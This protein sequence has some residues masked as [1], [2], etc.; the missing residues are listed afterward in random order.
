[1]PEWKEED[2][3]RNNAF[4]YMTCM[5]TPYHK[6]PCPGGNQ[7]YNFGGPFILHHNCTLGLSD[8]CLRV[9]KK[10]LKEIMHFHYMTY[11]ASLLHKNPCLGG[12]EI[13]NFGRPFLCHQYYTLSLYG[14]CQWEEKKVFKKYSN[15]IFIY[16]YIYI[17]I[18][19]S[20]II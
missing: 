13:Y 14:P 3:Q 19:Y 8:L 12:H 10:I 2:S 5:A 7:I 20:I 6:N 17:Y 1:M 18:S 11:M 16:I 4:Q 9:E 15:F